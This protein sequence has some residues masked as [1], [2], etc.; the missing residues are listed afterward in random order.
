MPNVGQEP[1]RL[2]AVAAAAELVVAL[3]A[4]AIAAAALAALPHGCRSNPNGRVLLQNTLVWNR[5][6][7]NIRNM[8]GNV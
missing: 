7:F 6:T 1:T 3:A 8:C 5:K 4:A 2:T